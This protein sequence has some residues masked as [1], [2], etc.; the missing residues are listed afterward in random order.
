MTTKNRKLLKYPPAWRAHFNIYK[1]NA[2]ARGHEFKLSPD[3]ANMLFMSDC[4]YC[5]Q[6]PEIRR[7][8]TANKNAYEARMSGIDRVDSTK[9]YTAANTVAAC[10]ACNK[11]KGTMSKDEFLALCKRVAG[12]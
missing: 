6:P 11:A 2:K 4:H 7:F 12:G 10:K 5:D 1:S 8:S 3:Q 9:G